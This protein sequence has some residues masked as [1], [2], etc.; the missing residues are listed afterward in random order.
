MNT[1]CTNC[2]TTLAPNMKFCATCG[3]GA[4]T[5]PTPESSVAITSHLS[6]GSFAEYASRQALPAPPS[7]HWGVVLLITVL[8]LGAFAWVWAFVQA[9]WVKRLTGTWKPLIWL[10]VP[11]SLLVIA[12][13]RNPDATIPS[14]FGWLFLLGV[15]SVRRH[16]VK[17]YNRVE[18]INLKIG[19][20]RTFLVRCSIFS[21]FSHASP[22]SSGESR[23][24]LRPMRSRLRHQTQ[25]A[26]S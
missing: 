11:F 19:F 5:P 2:G 22:V 4:A 25:R 8:T 16:V 24:C 6:T 17:H 26:T 9:I 1:L 23:N 13:I 15:F 14:A 7:L 10:S 12:F 18:P 21:T 3:T 20:W